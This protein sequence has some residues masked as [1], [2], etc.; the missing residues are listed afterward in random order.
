M[1]RSIFYRQI[2]STTFLRAVGTN[3][4]I[5]IPGL[6][7]DTEYDVDIGD[8]TL[9]RLRTDPT[10]APAPAPAPAPSPS[11]TPSGLTTAKTSSTNNNVSY[12]YQ[13][14]QTG[15]YAGDFPY[16]VGPM[17]LTST[18][19]ASYLADINYADGG[20]YTDW[21][22]SAW[23]GDGSNNQLHD[24]PGYVHGMV[25][26]P[27]NRSHAGGSTANNKGTFG[28][29]FAQGWMGISGVAAH[30]GR[31]KSGT[32]VMPYNSSYNV[33][34][35]KTG[36]AV[37]IDS[38]SLV[39][40][41][42][43]D[44][45]AGRGLPN[46][47]TRA[48]SLNLGVLTVVPAADAPTLPNSFR[49]GISGSD[50]RSHFTV[51][52][53]DLS[54]FL[55]L[56]RPAGAPTAA[57]LL[58][59]TR[60]PNMIHHSMEVVN[61]G[62]TGA[63]NQGDDGYAREIST[64]LNIMCAAM[65]F[66]Y[67]AA[68]KI[69]MGTEIVTYMLDQ[70]ERLREG[71][72]GG[73]E[74]NSRNG[75]NGTPVRAPFFLTGYQLIKNANGYPT[76]QAKVAEILAM[77]G[78]FPDRLAEYKVISQVDGNMITNW[79]QTTQTD[80]TVD[81]FDPWMQGVW[82]WWTH[83]S[84]NHITEYRW[85]CYVPALP[86][87]VAML[88]LPGGKALHGMPGFF[89]YMRSFHER[90]MA[91]GRFQE[92]GSNLEK[93]PQYAYDMTTALYA[94]AAAET[95]PPVPTGAFVKDVWLRM[96][97]DKPLSEGWALTSNQITITKNGQ[98]YTDWQIAPMIEVGY[99]HFGGGPVS[100]EFAV[101]HGIWG[102][103]LGIKLGSAIAF[104]DEFRISYAPGGSVAAENKLRSAVDRVPVTAF[105]NLAVTNETPSVGGQNA[106]YPTTVFSGGAYLEPPAGSR[107]D[108]V[109]SPRGTLFWPRM[110]FDANPSGY[111]SG[112]AFGSSSTPA[113]R[114]DIDTAGRFQIILRDNAGNV[115]VQFNTQNIPL[116]QDFGLLLHWDTSVG[117]TGTEGTTARF[118]DY[119]TGLWG[120]QM[121]HSITTY[122][123]Q[124]VGWNRN[125]GNLRVGQNGIFDGVYLNTRERVTTEQ[126]A[127]F[128]SKTNGSL[129]I[130]TLGD[131][132]TGNVPA[133]FIIGN[134]AQ[135]ADANGI[136]RGTGPKYQRKGGGD[137]VDATGAGNPW[138]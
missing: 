14:A 3:G 87:Y 83:E 46:A 118:Y 130:G 27:G 54:G 43:R 40:S 67:P 61:A 60:S 135:L 102:T 82:N 12:N 136:N 69:A 55:N 1:S 30:G 13:S 58:G 115:A 88:A 31:P 119:S 85:I 18:A 70:H 4:E 93:L 23:V 122:T 116:G 29:V 33:D 86:A 107:L 123:G 81:P 125:L 138:V 32:Q 71:G 120:N 36:G 109:D 127:K 10:P 76:A 106:K 39:K 91:F 51:D 56:P 77:I 34:P 73:T 80:R 121:R 113:I 28:S 97:F 101:R 42:N 59:R 22:A 124:P 132:V 24:T 90:E 94:A 2:A 105:T 37:T 100:R 45:Q 19:P 66:D 129:D 47:S 131:G 21:P 137:I 17:T 133:L 112:W 68:D 126:R 79:K 110:R 7:P 41:I 52:D 16:V 9:R 25:I 44:G 128:H 38:G 134:A 111:M 26:N 49:P 96:V 103:N 35:G 108:T 99:T 20:G 62:N 95:A 78:N 92:A 8:G 63:L 53:L 57:H 114:L 75:A 74:P 84:S 6:Q 89:S 117:G 50:K 5:V 72:S 98:P 64:Y 15:S 48:D 11:P 104:G 65:H